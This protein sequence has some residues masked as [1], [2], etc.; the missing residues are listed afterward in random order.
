MGLTYPQYL[1]MMVLWEQDHLS[2]SVIADRLKL[3][4]GTLTP[5]LKRLETMGLLKRQRDDNDERK[6]RVTLTD[7]GGKLREQAQVVPELAA[8]ATGCA[9]SELDGLTNRITRLRDSIAQHSKLA[10]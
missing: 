3:D 4:S 5:L 7:E 8:A 6:V 9:L 10:T 1:V 2:L